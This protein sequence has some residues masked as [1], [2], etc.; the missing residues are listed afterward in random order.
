LIFAAI[1]AGGS[2]IR[3]LTNKLLYQV[4]G[5]PLIRYTYDRLATCRSLIKP[6]VVASP[7][8]ATPLNDMGFEVIID[9]MCLGPL[10]GI[11]TALRFASEVFVV[12][13]DMPNIDCCFIDEMIKACS[14]Y[15][16]A[17][18]PTWKTG[19]MEP[20][21]ALYKQELLPL[22]DYAIAVGELSIQRLVKRL[23]V[24][25]KKISIDKHL[26]RWAR[27]FANIN[28]LEDIWLLLNNHQ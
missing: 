24:D 25:V 6:V 20:L 19:H 8:M 9:N 3:F 2:S 28:T 10:S 13:G 15:D 17:C 11:Y 4:R 21:A 22:L 16:Y 1:L 5:K 12:G 7:S 26:S 14:E 18:F 27:V 23:G